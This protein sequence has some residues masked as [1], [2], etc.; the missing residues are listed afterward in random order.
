MPVWSMDGRKIAFVRQPGTG[1]APR[2]PLEEPESSW[3]IRVADHQERQ[4]DRRARLAC[5]RSGQRAAIRSIR[6]RGTRSA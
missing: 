2:N 6:L 3:S 4:H 1:G 5:G